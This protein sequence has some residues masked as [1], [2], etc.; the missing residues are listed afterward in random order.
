MEI[1]YN[2]DQS[3][4]EQ[5]IEIQS[6]IVKILATLPNES[7]VI[8]SDENK[9]ITEEGIQKKYVYGIKGL[10]DVL[11]CSKAHAQNIKKTGILDQAIIQNGRKI[12]V[13]VELAISLFKKRY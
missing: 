2:I 5:L 12:I 6:K 4:R 1:T 8:K 11:G 7:E 10:A 3:I 9:S 13:D